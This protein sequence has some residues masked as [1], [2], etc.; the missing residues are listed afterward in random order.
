MKTFK[1]PSI[2]LIFLLQILL[3]TT[4][5]AT[6]VGAS[7]GSAD[8]NQ[9]SF[10]YNFEIV[11]PKGIAGLK[12]PLSLSYS[13]SSGVNST[14]G[15]G[16]SLSGIS[17]IGK[18]SQTL[19]E[20]LN[21]SSRTYDYCLDGQR[22]VLV[23]PNVA[24][25]SLNST[26]ATEINN[27][28]KIIKLAT[29]W[30]VYSKD[31]LIYEL[32]NTTDS[33]DGNIIYKVNKVKDRY[34]NEINYIYH[35]T[36][37]EQ[38]LK[39][40]TYANNTVDFT[41]E[42][43]NDKKTIYGQG[44]KSAI[45]KRIKTISI[46]TDNTQI[47]RYEFTY[48]YENSNSKISSIKE[49]INDNCLEPVNFT[50]NTPVS[51]A[52]IN[53]LNSSTYFTGGFGD[54]ERTVVADF[55]ADG[56]PDLLHS[57]SEAFPSQKNYLQLNLGNGT[58]E[59]LNTNRYSTGGNGSLD[60]MKIADFNGDGLI[61]LMYMDTTTF[62]N[63][64]NYLML[65]KGDGT[66]ENLNTSSY[67]TG[68]T[69]DPKKT[70]VADFNNDGLPD[71][72]IMGSEAF[73]NQ[74]N[75]I[76]LNKGN[77]SFEA[78]N[79]SSY[80]TGGNGDSSRIRLL[81]V[82][83]D[84]LDD[85][86]YLGTES[87]PN[88]KN[89]IM[90]N[91][92]N[93]TFDSLNTSKYFTGGDGEAGRTSF[94]DINADG[95]A[96]LIY[97]SKSDDNYKNQ[98]N[99]TMLNKGDGTF[100]AFNSSKYFIA[101]NG[102]P[103]RMSIFDMN[104]DGYSDMLYMGDGSFPNQKNYIIYN[105]GDGTFNN[106]GSTHSFTGGANDI[107]KMRMEDFNGDG[108]LDLMYFGSEGFPSQKN[109]IMYSKVKLGTKIE[110]V[111]NNKDQTIKVGY[112]NLRDSLVYTPTSGS[113]YPR[114]DV[115]SSLMEVVDS[116]TLD[117]GIGGENVTTFKYAGLTMSS[118]Y[119]NLGFQT[120]ETIN[121]ISKIKSVSTYMQ[122][123]PFVGQTSLG[124]S[125]INNI[126]ISDSTTQLESKS[127]YSDD[128]ILNIEIK[129]IT[130]NK[131]DIDGTHMLTEI[132][133]NSNHDKY[134]NTRTIESITK[135]DTEE[136]KKITTS[137]YTNDEENWIL[138]RLTDASVTHFHADG[139]S[140]VK[141]S[142]FE[143]DQSKGT[144]IKEIIEPN[145]EKTVSKSYSYDKYGNKISESVSA[146]D[147]QS[148]MTRY[149]YD[150]L[151]KNIIKVED[152]LH[153]VESSL[154]D[155]N[156]RITQV[157][158]INGL[159]TIWSYDDM[160][161]KINEERPDGTSTTWTHTWDTSFSNAMYKVVESSTGI[162]PVE[163]YFD[164]LNRKIRVVKIG[165]NGSKI[166]K[167]VFFNAIGQVKKSTNPY[168]E[169]D[170]AKYIN[171]TYDDLGRS[172]KEEHSRENGGNFYVNIEYA[173]FDVKTI[174]PNGQE[175][176]F[177]VNILG[178]KIQTLEGNSYINFKYD[179]IGN[180]IETT[181]S[182]NNKISITYDIFGNKT[183]MNDP[184]MGEWTYE[185]NSLGKLIKQ[186]DA[187]G[188]VTQMSY[189][190]LGRMI[191]KGEPEDTTLWVYDVAANGKGKLAYVQ[192]DFYKKEY[193]YDSLGRPIES[194]EYID[195]KKFSTKLTYTADGKLD[196]TIRPDGFETINEYNAQGFLAAVKSPIKSDRTIN[197]DE[198]KHQIEE[199]LLNKSISF[200]KAMELTSQVERYRAKALKHLSLAQEYESLDQEI[201]NHLNKTAQLMM[202]TA[203]ELK[204]EALEHQNNYEIYTRNLNFYLNELQKYNDEYLY[205]WLVETFTSY[206]ERFLAHSWE[207]LDE[208][209]TTL[210]TIS[211]TTS[212]K[213]YK[214]I[215]YFYIEQAKQTIVE[216]KTYYEL[217]NNYKEKYSGLTSGANNSYQGM[218]KD[219]G[220]KYFYKILDTDVF[221][222]VTRDIVGN[223]LIT[224]RDYNTI[225]GQLKR[226]QTGYD[227]N[228]DVR[229]IKY[230]YDEMDNVL[231]KEDIKQKITHTYTYDLQDQIKSSTTFQDSVY[232]TI[233]Y[234][235]DSIG[236][237]LN[238]SDVGDYTYAKAH[239]LSYAGAN[240]Y[241]YDAN[242][243]VI[244][245]NN[246]TI[247]Y[248]SFN[249]PVLLENTDNKTEFF[250]APNRARYKK[251]HNGNHTY[252]IGKLFEQENSNDTI[253]Y[254]NYIYAGSQLIAIHIE[255]DDGK[256]LLPQNRYVHKDALGSI[257]TITDESGRVIQRL[258][259]K[260]FGQKIEQ[261]WINNGPSNQIVIKRG[262]TGHEHI[263]EHNLIHMNGRVYDPVT[264]RFLSAD[265]N[266][267][268]A[269]TYMGY[270]R[271]TYV[272]NN[273]LKYTDPSGYGFFSRV[274][275]AFKR[276]YK[277]IKKSVKRAAKKIKKTIKRTVRSV[278][279]AV[280]SVARAVVKVV[281]KVKQ[282]IKLVVVVVVVVVV[283]IYAPSL[284]PA[285]LEG[286]AWGFATTYAMTGDFQ[287][288]LQGAL[289]GAL[290]GGMGQMISNA[291]LQG[292]NK[293]IAKGIAGGINS[294]ING[295][296]FKDGF[297]TGL[298][299]ASA[300]YLYSEVS[301]KYNTENGKSHAFLSEDE[302][303]DVGKQAEYDYGSKA[304]HW[305]ENGNKIIPISS[306]QST[307]M[308]FVGKYVPFGDAFAEF[309]DGIFDNYDNKLEL[310]FNHATNIPT[311][312]VAYPITVLAYVEQNNMQVGRYIKK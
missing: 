200:E 139:S 208:A 83:S 169:Y 19:P 82:N 57:G 207:K 213:I 238:K 3:A 56:L 191:K 108:S 211:D 312:L 119:G 109:Y 84:G 45:N 257:D 162:K 205:K 148:S 198:I 131:Y 54:K 262:F 297:K 23:T 110:K 264:G 161:R 62:P 8:V 27:H 301:A 89:Y 304:E 185:Y 172:I 147:I 33:N 233:L 79:T 37:D 122:T 98:K 9:G 247:G 221:G 305:D 69:G 51:S 16:F 236:N 117:D 263:N 187:K 115:K 237:I 266:I 73:P 158:N 39:Q 134:G 1:L 36:N 20:Q 130:V 244:K 24:Y 217:L 229:D 258:S 111:T 259:Y 78:L 112:T 216:A 294:K 175:S 288:A 181:D 256:M 192:T 67:F 142:A 106:M 31:G 215:S 7:K 22:L 101:G 66:F 32:G 176:A 180:L 105:K 126:K 231:S 77:G 154:Y 243:N 99:Y 289:A 292:I 295:G 75:Y 239:Q 5:N 171:Y 53:S 113:S 35:N 52:G 129:N 121:S 26:Y 114:F 309:H 276:G 235:Y 128:D 265:P 85:I 254:K 120:I 281:K 155:I 80:F 140:I 90:L 11:T 189:D 311:M 296:S 275:K 159:N 278:S 125:Y 298:V 260:P 44:L 72:M 137:A 150:E 225:N 285:M 87:F 271:Y 197:Y 212:L 307:V 242:G 68:G 300:K 145:H 306:D 232:S 190:I 218:F 186:T 226:I 184:D 287:M 95:Q 279:Q 177:K 97:M 6:L 70:L 94:A 107:N 64:K 209:I 34:D 123:Y 74:K 291:G 65:N 168:Y 40:I 93:G 202:Q 42:D 116:L 30:K 144:L 248:N 302:K 164:T 277:R 303:S 206:S 255:E 222:R 47:N 201:F 127:Y 170:S 167:D 21:D 10:S 293:V 118:L 86:I 25:G 13:S 14:L 228:N 286:A 55:N 219:D 299:T 41:Y 182:K 270:N 18:C 269:D 92:G 240:T 38:F 91:K 194:S 61:D 178:Q 88:Q 157:T 268:G 272:K 143:Y 17:M 179:A 273:P 100:E 49:C 43:R 234:E 166:Y 280:R 193:F 81:D 250:Y 230:I 195:N 149:T 153:N 210:G 310:E 183:Y 59:S 246:T 60:R 151:G 245:R 102:D 308:K 241:E 227:G 152:V 267:D 136:Y 138:S 63:Q 12:A 103:A 133:N 249:K 146:A 141:T 96:D 204:E 71:L 50:W 283:A 29:S 220:Y 124:Q 214:D 196:K 253:K 156:N 252:Y 4:S 2:I 251:V 223:G 46:K 290:A 174:K 58:F 76:M 132:T 224:T 261:D 15:V 274:K 163:T 48:I 173:K 160:G 28:S 165:F 284:I 282:Y 135:K 188:Q 199:N 104:G 203:V